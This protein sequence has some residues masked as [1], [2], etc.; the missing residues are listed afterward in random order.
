MGNTGYV[1]NIASFLKTKLI[2]KYNENETLCA[3]FC[4]FLPRFSKHSLSALRQAWRFPRLFSV[5]HFVSSYSIYFLV[6]AAKGLA[7]PSCA[8]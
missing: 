7:F 3:Y 6:H 5:L 1:Q 8:A 2:T 4:L